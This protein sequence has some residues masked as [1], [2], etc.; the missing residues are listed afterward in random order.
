MFSPRLFIFSLLFFQFVE[1]T[2]SIQTTSWA[3]NPNKINYRRTKSTFVGPNFRKV[4]ITERIKSR[5]S[6]RN[7]KMS[8]S[9]PP[10]PSM[11][12]LFQDSPSSSSSSSSSSSNPSYDHQK[13]SKYNYNFDMYDPKNANNWRNLLELIRKREDFFNAYEK[14]QIQWSE[15]DEQY[16]DYLLMKIRHE[17]I[18]KLADLKEKEVASYMEYNKSDKLKEGEKE[19]D[20]LTNN[21]EIFSLSSDIDSH[22][23]ENEASNERKTEKIN[24]LKKILNTDNKDQNKEKQANINV[25]YD[26]LDTEYLD[27]MSH[28]NEYNIADHILKKIKSTPPALRQT[29]RYVWSQNDNMI[30]VKIPLPRV[31]NR[32]ELNFMLTENTVSIGLNSKNKDFDVLAGKLAGTV[33]PTSSSWALGRNGK[34][35]WLDIYLKKFSEPYVTSR[36]FTLLAGEIPDVTCK[37]I[38]STKNYIWKQKTKSFD[39]IIPIEDWVKTKNVNI[40]IGSN[41][42][43]LKVSIKDE[44][45]KHESILLSGQTVGSLNP[46]ECL[47]FIDYDMIC[48]SRCIFVS[49]GK[50]KSDETIWSRLLKLEEEEGYLFNEKFPPL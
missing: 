30:T 48:K 6:T 28:S 5:L 9:K 27:E 40:E 29:K 44:T 47:W 7:T 17:E 46:H 38:Y 39:I 34:E 15:D 24:I 45:N 41:K 1:I 22:D 49:I 11:F 31:V 13:K 20:D 21:K 19:D 33:D 42:D 37:Y 12:S 25:D 50:Y 36:W 23:N 35:C 10:N 26:N 43:N 18:Q 2:C 4:K 8:I 14:K 16:I 32:R 3:V